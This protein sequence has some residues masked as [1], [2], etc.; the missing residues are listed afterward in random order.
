MEEKK[1]IKC[2][3]GWI[4]EKKTKKVITNEREIYKIL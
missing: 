3:I 1:K 4:K 2:E